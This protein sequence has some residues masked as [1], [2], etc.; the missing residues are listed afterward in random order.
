MYDL[1]GLCFV[2]MIS[3]SKFIELP[4]CFRIVRLFEKRLLRL[5]NML[6]ALKEHI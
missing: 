3:Y 5:R 4:P 2:K 1:D 6:S